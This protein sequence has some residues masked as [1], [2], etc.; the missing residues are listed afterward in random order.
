MCIF[1][2]KVQVPLCSMFAKIIIISN[3]FL[4]K[5]NGEKNHNK[6]QLRSRRIE[7]INFTSA[8]YDGV[9]KNKI[10]HIIITSFTTG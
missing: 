9:L 1:Y 5:I 10:D 7:N 8:N 4:L 2:T 3:K 6:K